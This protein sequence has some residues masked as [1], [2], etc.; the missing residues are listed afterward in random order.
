MIIKK[1]KSAV[2]IK[3]ELKSTQ[4]IL[5]KGVPLN[6]KRV[7]QNMHKDVQKFKLCHEVRKY[8]RI[9]A[10]RDTSEEERQECMVEGIIYTSNMHNIFYGDPVFHTR[11]AMKNLILNL[12]TNSLRLKCKFYCT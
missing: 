4:W 2:D 7:S 10:A 3:E 1:L 5:I 12:R 11:V 9:T 8:G 6:Q